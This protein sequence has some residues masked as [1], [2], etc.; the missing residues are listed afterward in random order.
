MAR[1]CWDPIPSKG[2]PAF[3]PPIH[4]PFLLLFAHLP[5][6]CCLHRM[7]GTARLAAVHGPTAHLGAESSRGSHFPPLSVMSGLLEQANLLLPN[8]SSNA[9]PP[10]G[11]IASSGGNTT[12]K[13]F[14]KGGNVPTA[15]ALEGRQAGCG[16][17][18]GRLQ[19][20][21]AHPARLGGCR[22]ASMQSETAGCELAR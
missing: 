3:K 12:P 8:S 22:F 2:P 15:Q 11:E 13:G 7:Q 20:H 6:P 17:P 10:H 5:T 4:F 19:P 14:L 1:C 18:W 9:G 16:A 21:A